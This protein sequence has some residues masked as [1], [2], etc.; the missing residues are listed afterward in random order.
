MR[1]LVSV[2]PQIERNTNFTKQE[3]KKRN[4]ASILRREEEFS[5]VGGIAMEVSGAVLRR[6][7]CVSGAGTGSRFV[8]RRFTSGGSVAVGRG[9][10]FHGAGRGFRVS[11]RP[12]MDSAFCDDGHLRYYQA[13]TSPRCGGR[14]KQMGS[15]VL[16]TKKKLKLLKG[17]SESLKMVS[18]LG[19]PLDSEQRALLDEVQGKLTSVSFIWFYSRLYLYLT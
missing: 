17:L 6:V 4:P 19:F 16:T 15:A 1:Q 7:T 9:A 2:F 11:A 10:R 8:P 13:S 3:T 12:R 14:E 18:E 5:S